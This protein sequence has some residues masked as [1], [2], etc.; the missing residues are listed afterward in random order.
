MNVL[1]I[2]VLKS[3]NLEWLELISEAGDGSIK[4]MIKN[5]K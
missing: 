3:A 2:C 4:V 5:E 1:R